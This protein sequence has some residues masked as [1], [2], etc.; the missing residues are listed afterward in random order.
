MHVTTVDSDNIS[1]AFVEA[2]AAAG[3]H[4]NDDFNGARRS[5]VG[6]YQFMIR[7][8]VR[9]SA[10]AA[11]IGRRTKPPSVTVRTHAL[12]TRVLFDD[13]RRATGVEL[14]RGRNPTNYAPR[15]RVRA[16]REVIL[17]AGAVHTP[18][19]LLLS[20]IGD[21]AQ[22]EPL[23]IDV[24]QHSP[25]VGRGLADGVYDD[26]HGH[27]KARF[28]ETVCFAEVKGRQGLLEKLGAMQ[29][30]AAAQQRASSLKRDRP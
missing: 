30:A 15:T 12:V 22:L 28:G 23:G 18:K 10:A 13:Q 17:A 6:F 2:G 16:R 1:R 11:Y 8:G 26:M 24:V 9:D 25:Y 27:L 14:V 5:G 29:A 20:G 4:R 3:L 21:R 7:D 19:L